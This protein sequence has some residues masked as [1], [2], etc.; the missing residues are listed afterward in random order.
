MHVMVLCQLA[1]DR[2]DATYLT[3]VI[4]L[5]IFVKSSNALKNQHNKKR[6]E[7]LFY[8]T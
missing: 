4:Y 2:L 1:S 6:F 5:E 3:F 8:I 7:N